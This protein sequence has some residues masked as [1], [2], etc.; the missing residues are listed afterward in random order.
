[1][2]GLVAQ[3]QAHESWATILEDIALSNHRL[4]TCGKFSCFIMEHAISMS[5]KVELF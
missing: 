3:I 4:A 2:L 5:N 1:M